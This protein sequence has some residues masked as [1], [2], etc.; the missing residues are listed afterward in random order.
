M[1]PEEAYILIL[2]G[3]KI[4]N[5][6]RTHQIL[7]RK[8]PAEACGIIIDGENKLLTLIQNASNRKDY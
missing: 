4:S 6:I 2:N 7:K 1:R 3:H 5:H 8:M